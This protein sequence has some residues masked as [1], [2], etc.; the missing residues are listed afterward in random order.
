M[1]RI[2]H[3]LETSVW[4]HRDLRLVAP[5]R[6][7]NFLAAE[8]VLVT[9]LLLA[10]DAGW[11]SA[12]TAAV[13]AVSA[14]PLAVGAPLA[15]LV[16]DRVDS[17]VLTVA[18]STWQAAACLAMALAGGSVAVL[19]GLLALQAGQ[20]LAGPAWQALVPRVVGADETTRAFGA[21]QSLSTLLG[22]L[23]PGVAGLLFGAVGPEAPLLAAAACFGGV[24]LA[25]AGVRTRRRPGP[26]AAGSPAPRPMD[27]LRLLR[28]DA[29]LGP[30]V[31][32]FVALVLAVELVGV[33]EV[34]LVR[35]DLGAGAA[36]YGAVGTVMACG[37]VAG[38]VLAG[39]L[40]GGWTLVRGTL[41]GCGGISSAVLLGA[42]SPTLLVFAG[43]ALLLGVA[44]GVL[45]AAASAVVAERTE[46]AHRGQ[47]FAALVGSL[48]TASVVGL[49]AGGAVG[50]LLEPRAV[51]ALSGVAGLAVTAWTW[52]RMQLARPA[53]PVPAEPVPAPVPDAVPAATAAT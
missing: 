2:F 6:A 17:K 50:A 20:A 45:N 29:V 10:H 38:A 32:G 49:V 30:L 8:L 5:A 40:G 14:L 15:G 33:V 18:A 23:G 44:Q 47:V 16:V 11:G 39:R 37:A 28:R 9:L 22:L 42:L 25:A 41:L 3:K 19:A 43:S 7:L 24:A 4:R 36:A 12:G 21:V 13:L 48:R 52:R 53:Q 26:R 31:V 35:D 1:K 46:D 34:F 27:G 51:L